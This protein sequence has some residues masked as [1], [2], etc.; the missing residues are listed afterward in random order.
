MK[1]VKKSS[2]VTMI[3]LVIT[4]IVLI[5]L[6][7]MVTQT[8]TSSIRNNRF[9]RLKYEM[10]IIQKNVAVWAEKYKDYEK[11]EI[12]LGTAVP[13][14]KI[15][16]CKDEIRILR[17]SG[18]KNL[19]ISDKVED[20]RYFSPST[21]D[22][23]QINGIENDYFID[24]KNQVAILVEGYEYEGKTYYIIDQVRDVVRGGI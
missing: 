7:S 23:L 22:N 21:F 14:S 24:I 2:G 9:E 18:I 13:T 6:A 10:E 16:I 19:V 11:T 5:I 17:E 20:Y 3:S 8:G 15:P 12:K 4:V 1:N